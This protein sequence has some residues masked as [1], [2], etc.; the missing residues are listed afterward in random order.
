M[1]R[2]ERPKWG[3]L[4]T[5]TTSRWACITYSNTHL[6]TVRTPPRGG[7]PYGAC[8]PVLCAV[9]CAVRL[10]EGYPGNPPLGRP[11]TGPSVSVWGRPLS[12][13]LP[14][15]V[16]TPGREGTRR[17]GRYPSGGRYRSAWG[18]PG[19]ALL[20]GVPVTARSGGP[21]GSPAES[22]HAE[23]VPRK[24]RDEFLRFPGLQAR[25][26]PWCK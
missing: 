17:E 7:A 2:K 16:G 25:P 8:V 1:G 6:V 15:G 24:E 26:S 20:A 10:Q 14:Q 3:A 4:R 5:V 21:P 19:R 22:V 12:G 18:G 23:C 11:R 9:R 13:A